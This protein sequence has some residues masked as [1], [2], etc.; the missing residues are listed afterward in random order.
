MLRNLPSSSQS[1]DRQEDEL[2]KSYDPK[3]GHHL[4]ALKDTELEV[5]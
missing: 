1:E 2:D 3:P 5:K 4:S